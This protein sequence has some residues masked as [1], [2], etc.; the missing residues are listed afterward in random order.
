M[1]TVCRVHQYA[2]AMVTWYVSV[3]SAVVRELWH[4]GSRRKGGAMVAAVGA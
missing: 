3:R 2:Y 1:C 4:G